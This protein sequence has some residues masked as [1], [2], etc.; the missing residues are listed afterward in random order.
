MTTPVSKQGSG[1]NTFSVSQSYTVGSGNAACTDTSPAWSATYDIAANIVAS[2][3]VAYEVAMT[4]DFS[5]D[6]FYTFS[7]DVELDV[8]ISSSLSLNLL[9]EV[10]F[11]ILRSCE[12]EL[13]LS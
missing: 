1:Q 2:G 7:L 13:N 11:Q 8:D 10:S 3:D 4:G 6:N 12:D 9:G 5:T